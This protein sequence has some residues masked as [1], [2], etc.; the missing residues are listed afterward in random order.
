MI[1]FF[2]ERRVL[3]N[4]L[5]VFIIA[6]GGWQFLHVRR[7]AFPEV[8]FDWV[9]ITTAYPGAS[10]EEV[11]RLVTKRIEDQLRTVSGV[12]KVI[13]SSIE[14]RS[15]VF[16]QLDDDLSD[17][18]SDDVVDH[19]EQAVNR[20]QDLPETADKP[21]IQ[22]LT[23][24]RPLITLSVAGGTEEVRRRFADEL[25]DVIEDVKGVSEVERQGYRKKEI[26]IEADREKLSRYLLSLS[27]V[28]GAVRAQNLD[29]S[30]GTVEIGPKEVWIRVV[31]NIDT[32]EDV[33]RII[34]RGTDE[35][36]YIRIRDV[37][38]VFETY[39]EERLLTRA[40]G[41]PAIHL[42]VRKL[43]SGD[44]IH[45]A[46]AVFQVK[47]K[48]EPRA[49]E[50]G[51]ELVVSDD[52][53]FFVRRRLKVMTNNLLQG[54]VLILLALFIFLD[55]RLALVAAWGV[56]ISFA[57]AFMVAVPLGFTINLM[58][59]MAFIIVLG[60][61]DDDSVVVAENIYRHLE[62]GKAPFQAAVEGAREV[63]VPVLASVSATS[64]AFLPFALM[65]GIMGKFLLMIPVI[66]VMAFLAS[67]FEAF[68][69]LPSHVVDL[70][71]LGKPVEE[72]G[73]GRWYAKVL[74]VY[75]RG[76]TWVM[77]HRVKFFLL[78]LAVIGV[79]VLVGVLRLKMVLFPPGLIDQVF[80]QID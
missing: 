62:M 45:L 52:I 3:T 66:V 50:Q 44:T 65:S 37:A 18:E 78:V 72:S 51:L 38:H 69:I 31:G 58:S 54:G 19:I 20:V 75:R 77:G 41:Q 7:E 1:K 74:R 34:L 26:W 68:F 80:I 36:S 67:A 11:E 61:L 76:M 29:A 27:E 24:D 28:A 8:D 21:L 14:N 47:D 23:S 43:K 79:T 40:N 2:L 25:A 13:S 33:E 17:R 22:E 71:P 5:T 39:E 15:I 63:V 32:A 73:D 6:V 57:A 42:N 70:M 48:Y 35:R 59:L 55:W 30:A 12:D 9:T 46:N 56:P 64:C 4:L 60:M 10:P 16:I 53:S 49:R